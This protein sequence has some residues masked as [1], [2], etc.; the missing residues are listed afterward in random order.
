MLK[1][2]NGKAINPDDI[3]I[4]KTQFRENY[5]RPDQPEIID[6]HWC[7]LLIFKAG[8]QDVLGRGEVY[9]DGISYGTETEVIQVIAEIT[10]FLN[11]PERTTF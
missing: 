5:Q 4:I 7:I 3:S 1:I 8:S 9:L 10:E 6:N 11:D 2:I